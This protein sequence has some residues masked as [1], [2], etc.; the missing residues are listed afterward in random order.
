MMYL[1]DG[2]PVLVLCRGDHDVNEIKLKR[3]LGAS[4]AR[5]FTEDEMASRGLVTGFVG[6]VNIVDGVRLV[7][8]AWLRGTPGMVVGANEADHHYGYAQ[9]GR[10]F[11]P[12]FFDLKTAIEGDL[13]GRCQSHFRIQRGIE[14][15]HVFYLGTKY[16]KAMNATFL[17]EDGKE[18]F[19]EM[20][21]YG[22]GVGR[23]AAAAI[24]QNFDDSGIIWPMPIAPFHVSLVRLSNDADVVTA[25]DAL[26]KD[27]LSQNIE[28]LY[29]D[30]D[31]RP[32]VKFKDNDLIGCPVRVTF[33]GR[34]LKEGLVELKMRNSAE[35]EKLPL[36]QIA[37]EV[38][39]RVRRL[40][41]V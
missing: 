34:S 36:D 25:A 33:G 19:I 27:L 10:D 37:A 21:C 4:L 13:C 26:Y 5:L 3:A 18:T 40:L 16:S 14:V 1:V 32:G 41:T 11:E 35:I 22:I 15:G 6:P 17:G 20:G 29:D 2:E 24:E 12:E 39:A 30:R 31:E 9:A 7:A 23:T 8:D 28:V 38:V